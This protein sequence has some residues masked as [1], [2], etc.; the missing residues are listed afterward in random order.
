MQG[1][2][3]VTTQ[4]MLAPL[5]NSVLWGFNPRVVCA[6]TQGGYRTTNVYIGGHDFTIVVTMQIHASGE[7]TWDYGYAMSGAAGVYSM[8]VSPTLMRVD[9]NV[10]GVGT[11][12]S[13]A[14]FPRNDI[15][16]VFFSYRHT[17]PTSEFIACMNGK[18]DGAGTTTIVPSN[19]RLFSIGCVDGGGRNLHGLIG[20]FRYYMRFMSDSEALALYQS[21]LDGYP[22]V[23]NWVR[24][25]RGYA[26]TGNRRRRVLICGASS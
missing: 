16:Q 26:S 3:T 20:E 21:F 18:V 19:N 25:R 24:P 1:W 23:L 4:G 8:G 22:D 11:I 9:H 5:K 6:H 10:D 2:S 12:H 13:T 17:P 7:I 14:S 15:V